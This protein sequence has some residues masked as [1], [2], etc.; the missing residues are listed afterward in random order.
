MWGGASPRFLTT[1]TK[2]HVV[3][4]KVEI[5]VDGYV[6]K[7]IIGVTTVDPATGARVA[8]IG[9]SVSVQRALVQRSC[10]I[11]FLDL[12]AQLTPTEATDLFATLRNEIR[13]YRGVQY[14][15]ATPAEVYNGTDK[16]YCPLGTF[17]IAKVTGT[18][19][20]FTV[21]GYDRLWDLRGRFEKPY[22]V[23]KG[24][25]TMS[26][27]ERLIRA[28]LPAQRTDIVLPDLSFTTLLTVKEQEDDP[29]QLAYDLAAACGYVP[30][31]DPLGTIRVALE[32]EATTDNVV[33]SFVP[34]AT[35]IAERPE[36]EIDATNAI[37]VVITIGETN[38]GT[39]TPARGEAFDDNPA[40]LTYVGKVGRNA[41]FYSSPLF[42]KDGSAQLAANTI[43]RRD[44]GISD[45]I[46][47][48]SV[49]NPALTSGDVV[50]AQDVQQQI[51]KFVI[52]DGFEVGLRSDAHQ[53]L[54]CRGQML[55]A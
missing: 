32:P 43:L 50:Y 47:V 42:T 34:G 28:R 12:D 3:C 7:E 27:L 33:W 53:D 38:D 37:N 1:L 11:E 35:N 25:P 9:G 2:G 46:I 48:S 45:T 55:S 30:Y 6:V 49:P 44:A 54:D 24:Q 21:Q 22:T 4:Q 8:S 18:Y 23:P 36:R 40:S 31:A 52:V 20:N 39:T 17:I 5:L 51:D 10:S 29:G 14:W 15:D 19:P 41:G 13:V 26:Q 16:E